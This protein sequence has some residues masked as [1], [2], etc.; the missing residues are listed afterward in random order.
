MSEVVVANVR[1]PETGETFEALIAPE[2]YVLCLVARETAEAHAEWRECAAVRI[3]PSQ[4][5][6]VGEIEISDDLEWLTG[7]EGPK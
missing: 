6:T 5:G 2:G 3:A 7:E 4:D 1:D